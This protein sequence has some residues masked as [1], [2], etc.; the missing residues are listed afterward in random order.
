MIS[1]E[2]SESNRSHRSL[3]LLLVERNELV[4]QSPAW[5]EQLKQAVNDLI[6]YDF[7][8]LLQLLY[9]V[10]VSEQ[11]LRNMLADFPAADAAGIISNLL[12]ERQLQK[13]K[14]RHEHAQRDDNIP[15]E[16][17]W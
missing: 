1:A 3:E 6:N 2:K 9:R 5:Y 16:E 10:D 17:K 8:S 15:D 13:I 4:V 7:D 12:L 11:K 14:S